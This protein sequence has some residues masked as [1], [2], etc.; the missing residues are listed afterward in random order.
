V[1]ATVFLQE[2][3]SRRSL[4]RCD[5]AGAEVRGLFDPETGRRILVTEKSLFEAMENSD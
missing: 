3:T 2:M 1:E 5:E 4:E